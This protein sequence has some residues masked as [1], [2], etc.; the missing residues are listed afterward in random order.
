MQRIE[1]KGHMEGTMGTTKQ[2]AR[3]QEA[4]SCSRM[5]GVSINQEE[6]EAATRTPGDIKGPMEEMQVDHK[7]PDPVGEALEI[8]RINIQT[9]KRH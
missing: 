3:Q 9:A 5:P 6:I 1:K 2:V 7:V 4:T 8:G